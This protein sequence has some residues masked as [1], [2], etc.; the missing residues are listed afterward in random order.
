M[1]LKSFSG[2]EVANDK[3]D[4]KSRTKGLHWQRKSDLSRHQKGGILDGGGAGE[5]R[6]HYSLKKIKSMHK[7]GNY[8]SGFTKAEKKEK[9]V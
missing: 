2:D 4:Q 6:R 9:G 1:S 5:N 8:K 7:R 3:S